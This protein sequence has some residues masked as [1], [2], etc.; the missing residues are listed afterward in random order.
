MHSILHIAA[1]K[2]CRGIYLLGVAVVICATGFADRPKKI[3]KRREV[4][5]GPLVLRLM[6]YNIRIG[7]GGG[8]WDGNPAKINLAPVAKIISAQHADFVGMQE[9]DCFRP[10]S[11]GINEPKW[12]SQ[13]LSMKVAFEPAYSIPGRNGLNEDYGV[14]L[15]SPNWIH[16]F[17]RFLLFKPDYTK[18]HTNYPDYFSEQRIL[19]HALVTI[20]SRSIHVF[21]THLGLTPDQREEQI[22]QIVEVMARYEG[23]KVLLGD[24][25][26]E[27][28]SAEMSPLFREYRDALAEG[29]IKNDGRKSFPV[30][31]NSREAIDYIFV[32]NEF[33]VLNAKVIRDSTSASDHNPVFA[34]VE[35]PDN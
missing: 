24:F 35:L 32:S 3:E 31:N 33:H 2:H 23:P 19:L 20:R 11:A 16:S 30:G 34:E 6:T 18:S 13:A 9:V 5:K 1:M 17:E 21:V 10:R 29:G 22:R 28:T 12:L 7:A 14:A 25:N 15:L 4:S 27:P 26:A 8:N